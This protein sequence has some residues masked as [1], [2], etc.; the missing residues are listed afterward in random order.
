VA[1]AV[2]DKAEEEATGKM[3]TPIPIRIMIV[4]KTE[5]N[6]EAKR[7]ESTEVKEGTNSAEESVEVKADITD[8]QK[9]IIMNLTIS[10]VDS[11]LVVTV[12]EK[13]DVVLSNRTI[14][15]VVDNNL[16]D[17]VAVD[18]KTIATVVDNNLEVADM[19]EVNK[20]KA[21]VLIARNNPTMDT[22]VEEATLVHHMEAEEHL[23][24]QT[25]ITL[26]LMPQH[27][28][29]LVLRATRICSPMCLAC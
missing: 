23:E 5:E 24:A 9:V 29:T 21:D 14:I 12:E 19:V 17:M 11:N 7:S 4:A 20:K 13:R 26:E 10:I 27:S 1:A 16:V 18:V 28:N 6:T 25:T 22:A 8:K 15:M 3:S 2:A